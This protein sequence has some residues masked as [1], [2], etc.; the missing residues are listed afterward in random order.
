MKPTRN[1]VK[2]SGF[3]K[4]KGKVWY[5]KNDDSKPIKKTYHAVLFNEWDKSM[6]RAPPKESS[7]EPSTETL[8]MGGTIKWTKSKEEQDKMVE[9]GKELGYKEEDWDNV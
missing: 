2:P 7:F 5:Q 8:G 9:Y 3:W 4:T 6:S 1:I